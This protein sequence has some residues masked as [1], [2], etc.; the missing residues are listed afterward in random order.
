MNGTCAG[1]TGAF[2]DQM[3][4]L[5]DTDAGGL[6]ELARKAIPPSIPSQA[7]AACSRKPMCSRCSTKARARRTSPRPSSRPWSRRPSRAWRAVVPF[8]ATWRCWAVLCSTFPNWINASAKRSI[9]TTSTPSSSPITRI[10]SW[11]AVRRSCGAK[12]TRR[13]AVRCARAPAQSGRYP[14]Q[15]SGAPG[16]RCS[17][18]SGIRRVQSAPRQREG[19]PRRS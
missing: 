4:A 16:R 12:G 15:R 17:P 3:A 8:A 13:A 6:N 14:G 11:P 7:V 10:C 9:S 19:S 2:I 5:L 1:G 18:T